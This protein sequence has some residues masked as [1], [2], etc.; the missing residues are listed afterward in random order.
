VSAIVYTDIARDGMMKGVNLDATR[1]LAEATSI[2]VIASG[3]VSSME[4]VKQLA[5]VADSGIAGAITGR[6]IYEGGLDLTEAQKW[7]DQVETT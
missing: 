4:D 3:G 7:C 1:R 6:A 2:P 5:S